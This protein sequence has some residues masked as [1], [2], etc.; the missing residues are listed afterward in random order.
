VSEDRRLPR[1]EYGPVQ[2]PP[3]SRG[4]PGIALAHGAGI[5]ACDNDH[6]TDTENDK[7]F[8]KMA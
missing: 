2:A 4:G 5:E 7:F 3:V 6:N 1:S 8:V